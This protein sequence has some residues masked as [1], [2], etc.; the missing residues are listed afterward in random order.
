MADDQ[1]EILAEKVNDVTIQSD[2]EE[3][4]EEPT[5]KSQKDESNAMQKLAD[6]D[7]SEDAVVTATDRNNLKTALAALHEREQ[8]DKEAERLLEKKLASVDI[9]PEDVTILMEQ[10]ELPKAQADRILREQNGDLKAA[11]EHLITAV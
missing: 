8:A 4:V 9:N 3:E 10:M 2:D 1:Q 11:L 7:N 5:V 6:D